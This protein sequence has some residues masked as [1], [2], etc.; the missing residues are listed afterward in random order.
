MKQA[1]VLNGT[2][3]RATP[4]ILFV[5]VATSASAR[6]QAPGLPVA[7]TCHA[8]RTTR[9]AEATGKAG[10]EGAGSVRTVK[11]PCHCVR[12]ED[13]DRGRSSR[14]DPHHERRSP[15]NP[16]VPAEIA[17]RIR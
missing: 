5:A 6:P 16:G 12:H 15:S 3:R 10:I 4:E 8:R 13:P 9:T 17:R 1:P 7:A 14:T 2:R 11:P